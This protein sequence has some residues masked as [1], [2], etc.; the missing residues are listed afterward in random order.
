[1]RDVQRQLA[2]AQQYRDH[3]GTLQQQHAE[4]AERYNNF[5]ALANVIR[6]N[7]EIAQQIEE[8]LGQDTARGQ[9]Q[10]IAQLPP[11]AQ[12]VIQRMGAFLENQDRQQQMVAQRQEQGE[13][14]NVH[15]E[16]QG[17]LTSLLEKKG[18]EAKPFLPLLESYV[19]NRLRG[20]G[21][22]AEFSDIPLIAAE[23]F[24]AINKWHQAQLSSLSDGKRRD[25]MLPASPGSSAPVSAAAPKY[26]LD[27]TATQRG[28]EMLK[29][30]GWKE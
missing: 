30:L 4:L 23:W 19:L 9:E 7:P 28:I 12:Q 21:E 18:F 2:E 14:A 3:Y 8:A 1:M 5:N 13:L 15:R 29:G 16:V 25:G 22:S 20:M 24:G 26:A 10:A 27:E 11:E 6:Q 17:T